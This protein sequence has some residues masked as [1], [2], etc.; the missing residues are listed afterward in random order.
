MVSPIQQSPRRWYGGHGQTGAAELHQGQSLVLTGYSGTPIPKKLGVKPSSRV[1]ITYP[2]TDI[3]EI[4]G[5]LPEGVHI[6]SENDGSVDVILFFT[7]QQKLLEDRLRR[8]L[9]RGFKP[10]GALWIA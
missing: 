5:T 10:A 2:P 4:F 8:S 9:Q 1:A 7:K 6:C 3:D